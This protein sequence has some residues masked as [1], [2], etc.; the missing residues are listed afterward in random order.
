MKG[1]GIKIET[2]GGKRIIRIETENRVR[3]LM[4]VQDGEWISW[5][6]RHRKSMTHHDQPQHTKN[7]TAFLRALIWPHYIT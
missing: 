7:F 6:A 5:T 2:I 3:I 4:A 1:S